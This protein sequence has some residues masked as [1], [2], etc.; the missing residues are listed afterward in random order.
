MLS[1]Y[2]VI[3][4]VTKIACYALYVTASL[5][6]QTPDTLYIEKEKYIQLTYCDQ[7]N[8]WDKQ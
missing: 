6:F 3:S 4:T 7:E 2:S 5:K 1:Q 8:L